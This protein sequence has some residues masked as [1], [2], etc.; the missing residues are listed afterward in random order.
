MTG[1]SNEQAAERNAAS[2]YPLHHCAPTFYVEQDDP[3]T[4]RPAS[5]EGVSIVDAT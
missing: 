5:I 3:K 4:F 1:V 2:S